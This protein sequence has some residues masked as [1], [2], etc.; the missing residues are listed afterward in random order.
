LLRE[1][2]VLYISQKSNPS[3]LFN[4]DYSALGPPRNSSPLISVP[5]FVASLHIEL[6]L[7]LW[8]EKEIL[9]GHVVE[10]V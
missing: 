6:N 8:K 2:D 9:S 1:E 3:S 10:K 5:K 7:T 4:S